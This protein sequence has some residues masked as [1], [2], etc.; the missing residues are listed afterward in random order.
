[1]ERQKTRISG[2]A[3]STEIRYIFSI[4]EGLY[5]TTE[6]SFSDKA[7]RSS[8]KIAQ[9]RIGSLQRTEAGHH[10]SLQQM[11]QQNHGG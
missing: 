9:N 8:I 11:E 5:R 4:A 2:P 10:A 1:M 6:V 7:Y 3:E